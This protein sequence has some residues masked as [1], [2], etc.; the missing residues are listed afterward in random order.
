V[1]PLASG[2]EGWR[3]RGLPLEEVK[4]LAKIELLQE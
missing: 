4:P 2:L 1:R 3:D